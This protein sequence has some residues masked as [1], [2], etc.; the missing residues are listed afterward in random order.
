VSSV[1]EQS[2]SRATTTPA[3]LEVRDLKV[4]FDTPRGPLRAVDG[5]SLRVALDE[6]DARG[7]IRYLLDQGV[8]A[9]A[10]SLL[11]SPKNPAH[12][13]RV[14]ELVAEMAPD[15][16]V[17]FAAD[18]TGRL[19]EYE[20]TMTCVMNAYIGP[21]MVRYVEAIE[22]RARSLGFA[23][24]VLFAQCA[25]GAMTADEVRR[26][27]ILTVQSGPVAG[28]TNSVLFGHAV[29]ESHLLTTDMGGTTFDVSVI[30]HHE[31]LARELATFE[32]FE[33]ALP[34][35]DVESIGA[36]GGSIAWIDESNRLNVGPRSAG[37]DPGPA[38]YGRGGTQP[39]VT[40]ADVVLG[41]IDPS[42]FLHQELSLDVDA[43]RR[44][45]DG[46]A[47][48]LGI[49]TYEAAAGINSIVDA[50]MA[51]LIRRMSEHRGLDPRTF[52]MLAF[53]GGGPVHAAACA[54]A[55]R[56]PKV[57]VAMP[58]VAPVWSA[59]G[60]ANADIAHLYTTPLV[61]DLPVAPDAIER[62]F[63]AM[64][65]RAW[66][67]LTSEGFDQQTIR[68]QR[69]LRMKHR[70]QVYDV[71]VPVDFRVEADEDVDRIDQ[72]FTTVYEE[73]YGRNSGYRAGGIQ[74]TAFQLRATGVTEK[75]PFV[76]A[77]TTST[78][79]VI[80]RDVYW[81]ELQHVVETPVLEIAGRRAERVE[82]VMA[83]P[84]LIQLPDTVVVVRPGQTA[85]FDA[86][87]N[88][89]IDTSHRPLRI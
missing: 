68:L 43:A 59:A 82:G 28:V 77:A 66:Q 80:A 21:L 29:G 38:C 19:G 45:I 54:R 52:T 81:P 14:R 63:V 56:V 24:T 40:D 89:V 48:E 49:G 64:E 51:D 46:L 73:R 34:M 37:A 27:P 1:N 5:V 69:S 41:L 18:L 78:G 67:A 39:T 71:E 88:I 12:E 86:G 7:R 30:R 35:L 26:S 75:A 32:R 47:K 6:A 61:L 58:E 74:I 17:T 4:T 70:L 10:I 62:T 15:V 11:W 87:G 55:A 79:A 23:G 76:D 25:G 3:L 57:I 83:G 2:P 65:R 85:A 72:R 44:A 53:G 16:F 13:H 50:N 9:V 20:R 33:M 60:A 42:M 31:P 36:G 22:Q 8:E 84:Y